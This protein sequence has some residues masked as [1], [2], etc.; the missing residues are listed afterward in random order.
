MS[1]V[2]TAPAGTETGQTRPARRRG[3]WTRFVLPAYSWLIIAYLV[4][5]IAVMVLY[6]F[7]KVTTGLPQVSFGW[8]GSE[9]S[10][11][12][13]SPVPQQAT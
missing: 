1:A 9:T 13:R 10:Y 2:V 12:C 5:P 4:F 11:C 8:N 3:R 7:N 6:S